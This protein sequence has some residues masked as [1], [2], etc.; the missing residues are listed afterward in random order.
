M[1]D[2]PSELIM[3]TTGLLVAT[4]VSSLLLST[5][6]S[7]SQGLDNQ[8]DQELMDA[9]TRASIINNPASVLWDEDATD[10]DVKTSIFVQ[11][12]GKT[13]LNIDSTYIVI[14]GVMM[15]IESSAGS[16]VIWS[17]GEVVEFEIKVD[18]AVFDPTVETE[19]ILNIGVTSALTSPS[20]TYSAA[21]V[22]R[23]V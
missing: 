1:G 18:N 7:I 21:E 17:V 10:S 6:G 9:K 23:L 14:G 20:G 15:T 4:I 2:G 3:L 12:S 13:T 8:G 11:N 22:I 16:P 19:Y 5:W